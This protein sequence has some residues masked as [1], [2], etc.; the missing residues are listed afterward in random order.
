MELL[1]FFARLFAASV[2]GLSFP[3]LRCCF[4]V[5]LQFVRSAAMPSQDIVSMSTAYI[6]HADMFISKVRVAV[7]SPPKMPVHHRGCISECDHHA[8]G[9]H[10][11]TLAVCVVFISR[12]TYWED[13]HETGHQRRLLCPARICPGYGGCFSDGMC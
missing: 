8:F 10:D 9:G 3:V 7:C 4:R 1:S 6:S 5:L 12:V 13:Q 11:P 2:I